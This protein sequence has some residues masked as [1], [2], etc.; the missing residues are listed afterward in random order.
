MSMIAKDISSGSRQVSRLQRALESQ[1]SGVGPLM[2]AVLSAMFKA[3]PPSYSAYSPAYAG[4]TPA[5]DKA[6]HFLSSKR[7]RLR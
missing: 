3:V 6:L 5:M 4:D 2:Q 7:V 1:E